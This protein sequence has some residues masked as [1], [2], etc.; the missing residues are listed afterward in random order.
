M[1]LV[2]V[3]RE[4]GE[5]IEWEN[6]E[7]EQVG[8]Q[9]P[10]VTLRRSSRIP[11]PV[12]C[13]CCKMT[14]FSNT[15]PCCEPSSVEPS[16]VEPSSVEEALS[17]GEAEHWRAAMME[18]LE[19]L[20]RKCT[21]EIVKKP[22][23]KNVLGCKWV[24]KVKQKPDGTVERYKARLV[25]Q[26]FS[27]IPGIDFKE[28]YSPV[29]KRKSIRLL[30]A[31]A[32]ENEWVQEHVDVLSAY[33]NSPLHEEVYMKQPKYF[34]EGGQNY[35]C[36]LNKSIYGLKQSGREWYE[37]IDKVLCDLKLKR[38]TSDPCVYCDEEKKLIIGVYVDDLALWGKKCK[39]EWAKQ[40]LSSVLEV[41]ALG[42]MYQMLSLHVVRPNDAE[43]IIDQ[44][45]YVK[46]V[47]CEYGM[48]DCKG[49]V[50]PLEV[51]GEG[52][53]EGDSDKCDQYL[54][55]KAVGNLLYLSGSSRPDL[56]Y[57]VCKISQKC[58]DPTK[59]DWNDVK[60]I[61]RYLKHTC[62]L[63]LNYERKNAPIEIYCDSDW[64]NDKDCRK[65]ISGY[66]VLLAGAA[67]CWQTRKQ[68]VVALSTVEAEYIAMCEATKE[69]LWLTSILDELGQSRFA[70]TPC[71]IFADNQG[72]ISF[73]KNRIASE[74]LKHLEV[75]Y[76]FVRDCVE[77]GK[78]YFEY[79]QSNN[80]LA[81]LFTKSVT[82]VK[83]EDFVSKLG[84]R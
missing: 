3:E 35:V 56:C 18:E 79:V 30:M 20:K 69:A 2:G 51:N 32:V 36:K 25:A 21:Y 82:G 42:N 65:S 1:N 8:V 48:S 22:A 76:N 19:N 67:I 24:L 55:R 23:G 54:Y 44:H 13:P 52:E 40:Q 38:L 58:N 77:K 41:R 57:A 14:I 66:V 26:G 74:K 68:S 75:K 64:A 80:N 73:S 72:A 43:I 9:Q 45:H 11:K 5:L 17:G 62:D 49:R 63:K 39:V 27:Q 28:T 16:S 46:Q 29:I 12:H 37:H 60:H 84:L 31:L 6:D 81:D 4:H 34:E 71:K 78:V 70:G 83:T 33:L 59:K 15:L 50:S 7:I 53:S 47:L 61:L 10:E